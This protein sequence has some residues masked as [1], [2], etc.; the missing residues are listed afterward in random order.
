MQAARW[1][2]EYNAW[3]RNEKFKKE[4]K[5]VKMTQ[6]EILELK[7]T[8]T[9]LKNSTEIFKAHFTVT[10]KRGRGRQ[11]SGNYEV[12]R[13]KAKWGKLAGLRE[14]KYLPSGSSKGRE[15]QSILKVTTAENFQTWERCGH[16][17]YAAQKTAHRFN[18]NKPALRHIVIKLPKV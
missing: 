15:R 8:V 14:N 3:T 5:T 13:A 18:H 10:K 11:D 12:R 9:E 16:S 6:R 17:P 2:W 7:S 1:R 4:R